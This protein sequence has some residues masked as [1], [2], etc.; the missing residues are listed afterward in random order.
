MDMT[1]V[2]WNIVSR[3]VLPATI[4]VMITGTDLLKS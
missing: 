3:I 1:V 2:G 4:E